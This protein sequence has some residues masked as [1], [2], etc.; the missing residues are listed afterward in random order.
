MTTL[1]LNEANYG[2]TLAP[3]ARDPLAIARRQQFMDDRFGIFIHF[4]LSATL[5]GWWQGEQYEGLSEWI[6][7]GKKIPLAEYRSLADRFQLEAFDADAWASAFAAAGAKYLVY[8]A[9]HHDGFAMYHSKASAYNIVDATPFGR[10]LLAELVEACRRHG[11]R[12]GVYYSHMIDWEHPHASG[13][14]ANDWDFD[15]EK[16]DF[17]VYWREK[18]LPQIEELC[19]G[20]G[21]LGTFWFDMMHGITQ[22]YAEEAV[23][24]VRKLQP[25]AVIN[26]RIGPSRDFDFVSTDDNYPSNHV[27][28]RD[29][30]MC[31]TMNESWG[32]KRGADDWKPVT[33]NLYTLAHLCSRNGNYLLNVGP[34]PD[35]SIPEP[36]LETLRGIGEFRP[37]LEKAIIGAGTS[38]FRQTFP[39]GVVTAKDQSLF[40]HV[41]DGSKQVIALPGGALAVQRVTDLLSGREL[42]VDVDTH[43]I[44][45]PACTDAE[46]PRIV[47]VELAASLPA[48]ET[49]QQVPG[50]TLQLE[51]YQAAIQGDHVEWAMEMMEPGRYRIDLISKDSSNTQAIRWYGDGMQG[52]MTVADTTQ[53]FTLDPGQTEYTPLYHFWKFHRHPILEIHIDAPGVY[54][55]ALDGLALTDDKWA[56][57]KLNLV[58]AEVSLSGSNL[59]ASAI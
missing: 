51:I 16:V 34:K 29:W 54:R 12:P 1:E 43:R 30:E 28:P 47:S 36:A 18:A 17:P 35:G 27:P 48:P 32:W 10:D 11:I 52:T 57:G 3:E 37:A 50:E 42:A 56:E 9:K 6:Q 38:P 59:I 2:L 23:A 58:R 14:Y 15:P 55:L 22:E 20:Y 5:E 41:F 4:G 33:T 53:E 21:E 46:R 44:A 31:A 25:G 39:W 13:P 26:S 24:L 45:L 7:K 19:T 49:P 40:L 8:V